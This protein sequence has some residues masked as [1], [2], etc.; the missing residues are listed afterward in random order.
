MKK[1]TL[2]WTVVLVIAVAVIVWGVY[3]QGTIAAHTPNP[4]D[5]KAMDIL[6]HSID[7]KIDVWWEV[8]IQLIYKGRL[9]LIIHNLAY[10]LTSD[11]SITLVGPPD[12]INFNRVFRTIQLIL[13]EQGIRTFRGFENKGRRI[14]EKTRILALNN[15]EKSELFETLRKIFAQYPKYFYNLQVKGIRVRIYDSQ[16][17][18][19]PE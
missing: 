2:F 14:C 1:R 3:F 11:S 8:H 7:D 13:K 18:R 16:I 15:T 4:E 6:N 5:L 10:R 12:R 9:Y 19:L 17:G